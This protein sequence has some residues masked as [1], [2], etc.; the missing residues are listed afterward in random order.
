ML[1]LKYNLK[2]HFLIHYFLYNK[3]KLTFP[4]YTIGYYDFPETYLR[5]RKLELLRRKFYKVYL[6]KQLKKLG[7]TK[8]TRGLLL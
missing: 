8:K 6:T 3:S 4:Y 5:S 2:M 7:I 1:Y